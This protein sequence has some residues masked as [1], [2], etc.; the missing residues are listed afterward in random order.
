M[1]YCDE[2]EGG[3]GASLTATDYEA[4]F[5]TQC[6]KEI[7]TMTTTFAKIKRDGYF[8]YKDA[9]WKRTRGRWAIPVVLIGSGHSG[10]YF[11]LD[12]EV[13]AV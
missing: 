10:V 13:E 4:G 3:C 12:T 2:H 11:R 6:G 9:V 5:C 8:R 7:R 1:T